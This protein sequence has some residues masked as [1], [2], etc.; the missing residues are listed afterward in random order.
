MGIEMAECTF[1]KANKKLY[2]LKKIRPYISC[3]VANRVYKYYVLPIFD[4]ADFL[5][6]DSCRQTTSVRNWDFFS[7]ARGT[8]GLDN[9]M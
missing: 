4:Y 2:L 8:V 5:I 7:L 9:L 6:I 1:S 3:A